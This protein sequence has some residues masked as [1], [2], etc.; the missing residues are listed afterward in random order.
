[1]IKISFVMG[2]KTPKKIQ[3]TKNWCEWIGSS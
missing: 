1:M 3:S 2:E